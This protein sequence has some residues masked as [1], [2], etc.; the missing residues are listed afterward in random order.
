MGVP[1]KVPWF[2][3]LRVSEAV[4]LDEM[5]VFA[6]GGAR[7]QSAAQTPAANGFAVWADVAVPAGEALVEEG[8][9]A[10]MEKTAERED[11]M[12]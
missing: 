4:G 2:R 11:G 7:R 5:S 6:A 1:V 9:E 3:R 10:S 8:C 12:G